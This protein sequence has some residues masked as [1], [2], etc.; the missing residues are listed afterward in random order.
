METMWDFVYF[1]SPFPS[2]ILVNTSLPPLFVCV[3]CVYTECLNSHTIFIMFEQMKIENYAL[4]AVLVTRG[5]HIY[6]ILWLE[7]WY[8]CE[9]LWISLLLSYLK[10]KKRNE[11]INV[12]HHI[13]LSFTF[14]TERKLCDTNKVICF[15]FLEANHVL[16]SYICQSF[17]VNTFVFS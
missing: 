13:A 6:F 8:L 15:R 9:N 3:K 4:A 1:S 2:Y 14:T 10:I 16:Y 5:R 12:F 7:S 17:G 11:T